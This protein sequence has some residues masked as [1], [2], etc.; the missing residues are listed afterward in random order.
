MQMKKFFSNVLASFVAVT[1]FAGAVIAAFFFYE[2]LRVNEPIDPSSEWIK[3]PPDL[4]V[5][6]SSLVP[7]TQYLAIQGVVSNDGS[8]SW[9]DVTVEAIIKAGEMPVETCV[10]HFY[11]LNAGGSRP[12][13]IECQGLSGSDH[14]DN[15]SYEVSVREGY[16]FKQPCEESDT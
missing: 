5:T 13:L 1:F 12:F 14:P 7:N 6:S 3:S 16:T 15:L 2:Q 9:R 8:E 10:T 4:V 11:V